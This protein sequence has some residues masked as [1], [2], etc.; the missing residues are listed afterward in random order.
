MESL[1]R[2][3]S[4]VG[5]ESDP[6]RGVKADP[7]AD[8]TPSPAVALA[9][10]AE[11]LGATR[12]KKRLVVGELTV[13]VDVDPAGLPDLSF[14]GPVDLA[15]RALHTLLPL[16]GA[17]E[18]R[19]ADVASIV[20]DTEPVAAIIEQH[21]SKVRKVHATA[22][23][24]HADEY[25]V[26][27][28]K[29]RMS[30]RLAIIG[31]VAAVAVV[32]PVVALYGFRRAVRKQQVGGACSK[33]KQCESGVCLEAHPHESMTLQDDGSPMMR[34]RP[35]IKGGV[36]TAGCT[37]DADCPVSMACREAGVGETRI[38]RCTPRDWD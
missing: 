30:R 31:A 10:I 23:T 34:A 38:Q 4:V 14:E 3:R 11:K 13:H 7:H 25:D 36:C 29:T 18:I 12:G 22:L 5:R 17:V 28:P 21:A 32:V 26:A 16:F 19:H 33:S 2:V 24:I 8:R 37:A 27:G 15:I 9:T 1:L 35:S 6:Y 20:D